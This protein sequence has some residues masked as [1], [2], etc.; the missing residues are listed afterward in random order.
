MIARIW[1]GETSTENAAAYA[2]LLQEEILP[3][4]H[5]IAGYRGAYGLR[6]RQTDGVRFITLTLWDSLEAV[7]AFAGEE[8]P[9]AVIEP[10]ARALLRTYDP[11]AEHYEV[12]AYP[13]EPP[14]S[15]R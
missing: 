4:F 3:S 11:Q 10:E 5:R 12:F 6:R 8:Y 1:H 7:R 14:A 15:G 2:A 9:T 13:G